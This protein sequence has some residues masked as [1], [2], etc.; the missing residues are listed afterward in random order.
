[1]LEKT[2]LLRGAV[3]FASPIPGMYYKE[4]YSVLLLDRLIRRM[5][6]RLRA[7][8]PFGIVQEQVRWRLQAEAHRRRD[9]D[10]R[11]AGDPP[12]DRPA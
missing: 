6:P 10:L 11:F 1:M 12:R 8:R 9:L 4:W 2:K 5:V 3:I 7:R